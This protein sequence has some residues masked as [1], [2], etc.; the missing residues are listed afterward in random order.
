MLNIRWRKYPLSDRQVSVSGAVKPYQEI[1]GI[2]FSSESNRIFLM[3][4][5]V[6]IPQL[7]TSARA[8]GELV[9]TDNVSNSV[10]KVIA[11]YLSN[12]SEAVS[13]YFAKEGEVINVWT[14]LKLTNREIR[15]KVYEQEAR[16]IRELPTYVLNFRTTDQAGESAP[17]SAEY[18]RI[19]FGEIRSNAYNE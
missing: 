2:V 6:Y 12:V 11:R 1:E 3:K 14:I 16:I 18:F 10:E 13:A 9:R 7:D 8:T 5:R 19:D 15:R 4:P 17:R